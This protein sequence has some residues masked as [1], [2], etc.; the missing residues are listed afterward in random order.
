VPRGAAK[1]DVPWGVTVRG[2]LRLAGVSRP[3]TPRVKIANAYLD[4]LKHAAATDGQLA[5]ALLRVANL[6]D[7][8]ETLHAP[9]MAR[10]VLK[11]N[12][13]MAR[14]RPNLGSAGRS[15]AWRPGPP[16]PAQPE[17]GWAEPK[18][19]QPPSS[20]SRQVPTAS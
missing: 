2:D 18:R 4:R 16:L 7:R 11:A 14:R 12:L 8:P 9:P 19:I 15:A 5:L 3:E 20:A 1:R 10:R 6:I 17:P 13:P